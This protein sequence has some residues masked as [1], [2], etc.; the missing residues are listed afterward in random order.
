MRS[1]A[2]GAVSVETVS[3]VTDTFVAERPRLVALAYR[4]LGSWAEA[5]D[6]AQEAWLRWWS[7]DPAA[8][9]SP[10]AWLTTVTTRLAI[11]HRRAQERRRERYVGPWLQATSRPGLIRRRPWT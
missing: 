9:R 8:V 7:V 1:G 2:R 6:V 4:M 3:T 10:E 11:D 5:E